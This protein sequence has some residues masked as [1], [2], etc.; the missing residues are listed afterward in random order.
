MSLVD[1]PMNWCTEFST[2]KDYRGLLRTGTILNIHEIVRNFNKT[3]ETIE[4]IDAY[5]KNIDENG[6][7]K[8]VYQKTMNVYFKVL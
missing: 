8:L 3:F 6:I 4:D 2:W 7:L 1:V 5:I